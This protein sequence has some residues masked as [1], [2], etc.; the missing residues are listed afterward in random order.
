M[1]S[2]EKG[3]TLPQLRLT[4]NPEC[5]PALMAQGVVGAARLNPSLRKDMREKKRSRFSM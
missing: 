5:A 1:L 2:S 4:P 3:Q